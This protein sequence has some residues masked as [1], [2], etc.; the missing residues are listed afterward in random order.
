M[1]IVGGTVFDG[2]GSPGR[3]ADIGIQGNHIVAMGDL[4]DA[5]AVREID[6]AGMVVAPGFIDVHTHSDFTLLINGR[7]EST[8]HQ[9][10]TT[11]VTGSCGHGCAPIGDPDLAR[12]NILGYR[13]DWGPPLEWQSFAEYLDQLRGQ[14]VSV[15]VLSLVGHGA[16]RL[17]VMGFAPRTATAE[18]LSQMSALL[19]DAMEAGAAGLSTGLEYPPGWHADL[20]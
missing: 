1:K 19:A 12:L 18:E 4:S 2:S 14:G 5:E 7:A 8:V 11:I 15:N 6:V 13:S 16:L 20:R 10:I 17:A 3:R 9:G